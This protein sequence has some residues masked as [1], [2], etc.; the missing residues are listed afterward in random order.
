MANN[1]YECHVTMLGDPDKI[2]KDTNSIGWKFSKIDGDPILGVGIKC[3]ATKHFP[4]KDVVGDVVEKVK[5][6]S[7]FMRLAG[8]QVLRDKV[9]LVVYDSKL[10]VIE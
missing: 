8:H 2:E 3:Y 5:G 4:A 10:V 1:Y 9:E 6:V 7:L